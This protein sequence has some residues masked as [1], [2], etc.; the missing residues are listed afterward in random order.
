MGIIVTISIETM[1]DSSDYIWFFIGINWLLNP[2][3][4]PGTFFHQFATGSM[5]T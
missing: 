3:L 1:G 5:E 2:I 4:E